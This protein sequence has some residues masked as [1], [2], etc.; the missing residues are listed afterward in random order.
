LPHFLHDNVPLATYSWLQGSDSTIIIQ[1]QKI[2]ILLNNDVNFEWAY[3]II[4]H[5]TNDQIN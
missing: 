2:V 4:L 5:K 3:K 1:F